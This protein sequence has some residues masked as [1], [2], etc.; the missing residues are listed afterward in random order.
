MEL[1]IDDEALNWIAHKAYI[2]GLGARNLENHLK[3]LLR[4]VGFD[5]FGMGIKATVYVSKI[6][7]ELKVKVLEK[8]PNAKK[9]N[10]EKMQI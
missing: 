8:K 6:G 3:S 1:I 10:K 9:M 7:N 5:Y 2:S 4:D